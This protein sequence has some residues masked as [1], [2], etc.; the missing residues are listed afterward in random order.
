M[1]KYK[2]IK[3]IEQLINSQDVAT[4]QTMSPFMKW[5]PK[6]KFKIK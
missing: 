1:E 5:V 4:L 2:F 6:K 3:K